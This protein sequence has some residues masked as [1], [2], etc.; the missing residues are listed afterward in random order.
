MYSSRPSI[1]CMP[2]SIAH[3]SSWGTL[4]GAISAVAIANRE[5]VVVVS[6][7]NVA[8]FVVGCLLLERARGANDST[9][10]DRRTMEAKAS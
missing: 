6:L 1:F 10:A 5:V 7:V 9:A 2:D 3:D 4:R 8:H